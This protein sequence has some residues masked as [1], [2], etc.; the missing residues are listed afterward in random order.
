MMRGMASQLPAEA[1][2]VVIGG[3]VMGTS[4]TFHAGDG[5]CA[6]ESVVLGYVR[7]AR[8]HGARVLPGAE[9]V[10]LEPRADTT[11]VAT[12]AGRVITGAVI[13][14]A[15]AWSPQIGGLAGVELPVT[16]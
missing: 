6:P 11:T 15:G 13:C 16:P 14:T 10:G 7:G 8:R 12:T 2:V 3:G 5:Y 1:K 9:V 4:A